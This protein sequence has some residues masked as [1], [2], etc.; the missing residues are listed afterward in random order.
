MRPAN[1][2]RTLLRISALA[3]FATS[4]LAARAQAQIIDVAAQDGKGLFRDVHTGYLWMDLRTFYGMSLTQQLTQLLPGF[5]QAALDEVIELTTVSMSAPSS[6]WEYYFAVAGGADTQNREILWGNA[7][8]GSGNEW[9]WAY[10]ND[11]QWSHYQFDEP[12]GEPDLGLW[13]VNTDGVVVATPE[14]ASLALMATGL[15][16]VVGVARRRKA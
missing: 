9:Y 1:V 7:S 16:G 15:I 12:G 14:P 13:A 10:D 4:A 3:V 8:N 6:G 11:T 5:R 2:R